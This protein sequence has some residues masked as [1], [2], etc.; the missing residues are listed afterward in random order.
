MDFSN[1]IPQEQSLTQKLIERLIEKNVPAV[2]AEGVNIEKEEDI[3]TIAT[4][5]ETKY[6]T[7]RERFLNENYF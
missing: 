5:I 4:A 2:L 7:M 3:E 1:Y 6:N